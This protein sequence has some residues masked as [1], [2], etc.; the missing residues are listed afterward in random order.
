MSAGHY[1]R[2][3]SLLSPGFRAPL[4]WMLANGDGPELMKRWTAL[5]Y[6]YDIV[7]GTGYNVQGTT[8]YVDRDLM[9]CLYD[10]A[11]AEKLVGRPINTGM[12]PDDTL[13]CL[14]RHETVEKVLMDLLEART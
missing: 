2:Y 4:A 1:H 5:N 3:P 13:D 6:D 11:Y 7:Y 14:L 9:R 12:S 10:A 8:R